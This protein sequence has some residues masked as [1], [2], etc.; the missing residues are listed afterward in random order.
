MG[1]GHKVLDGDK[2]VIHCNY[3]KIHTDHNFVYGEP[4]NEMEF[5][6]EKCIEVMTESEKSIFIYKNNG[7]TTEFEIELRKIIRGKPLHNTDPIQKLEEARRNKEKAIEFFKEEKFQLSLA[8]FCRS[9]RLILREFESDLD[10]ERE[11]LLSQLFANCAAC[12]NKLKSSNYLRIKHLCSNSLKYDS[13]NLKALFR[14]GNA[15]TELGEFEEAIT[16]FDTILRFDETNKPTL[17]ARKKAVEIK[18]EQM[19]SDKF[20]KNLLKKKQTSFS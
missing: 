11:K 20:S 18:N 8:R 4:T 17:M 9:I 1:N 19:K 12:F 3:S 5:K 15:C 7:V 13:E 10:M 2:I 14:R 16:D 6:I